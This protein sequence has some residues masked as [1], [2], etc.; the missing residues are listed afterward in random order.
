MKLQE[1]VNQNYLQHSLGWQSQIEVVGI[2]C[3]HLGNDVV[4]VVDFDASGGLQGDEVRCE[5]KNKIVDIKDLC[6]HE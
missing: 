1:T 2:L 4:L 5:A 3:C 6:N